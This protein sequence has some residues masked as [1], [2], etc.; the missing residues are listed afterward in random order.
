LLG[1][2]IIVQIASGR[3]S[4]RKICWTLQA[5]LDLAFPPAYVCL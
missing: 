5:I 3:F 2:R 4:K 1:E